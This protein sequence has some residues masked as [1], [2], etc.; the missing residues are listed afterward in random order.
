MRLRGLIVLCLAGL[1]VTAGV[2]FGA[3]GDY[4]SGEGFWQGND[5]FRPGGIGFEGIDDLTNPGSEEGEGEFDYRDVR[6]QGF[7]ARIVC[8]DINSDREGFLG[9]VSQQSSGDVAYKAYVDDNGNGSGTTFDRFNMR[10]LSST[11]SPN[12]S[13]EQ[14]LRTNATRV[15]GDIFVFDS[16][17]P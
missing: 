2:A 3:A 15:D 13:D 14:D 5:Q 9:L 7:H 6:G 17:T 4:A 10:R 11:E 8:V 1:V 16:G 12:C